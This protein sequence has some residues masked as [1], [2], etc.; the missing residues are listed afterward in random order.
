MQYCKAEIVQISYLMVRIVHELAEFEIR[1]VVFETEAKI[2]QTQI[3]SFYSCPLHIKNTFSCSSQKMDFRETVT[4]SYLEKSEHSLAFEKRHNSVDVV[5][6]VTFE[7][8]V[9]VP[10]SF[11]ILPH[12]VLTKELLEGTV[13]LL[14]KPRVEADLWFLQTR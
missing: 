13:F 4:K 7:V 12:S 10:F 8:F 1:V 14:G 6:A 9:R 11:G 2:L 5:A 3:D